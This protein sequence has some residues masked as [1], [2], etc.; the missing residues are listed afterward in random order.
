[1]IG[2][3]GLGC[4][5]LQYLVAAGVGEIGIVD[6]DVVDETN[7]HRQILFYHEDIGLKKAEVAAQKLRKLNPFI[8]IQ[9]F[10]ERL[11]SEN[12]E[13]IFRNYELVIDGS[14]NFATRYLV[15]DTCVALGKTLVFGSILKFEG[16]VSVFNYRNGTQYR[17]VF[18][19]TPPEDEVPNCA[20]IGVIGVLPGI[21]GTFMANEAIKVL[22][23]I[24]VVLSGKILTFNALETS[25]RVFHLTGAAPQIP[26]PSSQPASGKMSAITFDELSAKQQERPDAFFLIDVREEYEFEDFN[27]GG[28]NIPLYELQDRFSEIPSDRILVFCCQSSERSKSAIRLIGSL[29]QGTVLYLEGGVFAG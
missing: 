21:I 2:A 26:V 23:G 15:N 16:Q 24:G 9:S 29:Y 20:E 27:I 13:R 4:P 17:D 5:V 19:D 22:T 1:M 10:V 28:T 8:A 11:N 3:G 12:A 18:P 6:D 14:D 25:L 7:L